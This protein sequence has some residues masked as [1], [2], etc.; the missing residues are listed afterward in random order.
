MKKKL[1]S[2]STFFQRVAP[3][4]FSLKKAMGLLPCTKMAPIPIPEESHSISKVLLKSGNANTG[5]EHNLYLIVV[6]AFVDQSPNEIQH[7]F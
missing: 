2:N 7:S 6:N 4:G 1:H 3:L 5:V